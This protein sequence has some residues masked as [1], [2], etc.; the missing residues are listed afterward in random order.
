MTNSPFP[1]QDP[2]SENQQSSSET[3]SHSRLFS[4]L[5]LVSLCT[6]FSRVLGLVRDSCMAIL[7]GNGVVLDAFT[8]AFRLPNLARRL[9][10]EGAL[11]AAFLPHFI[12]VKE[13]SGLKTAFDL[14]RKLLTVL[15]LLLILIVFLLELILGLVYVSF[16]LSPSAQLL[17]TLTVILLPYVIFICLAAQ[18]SAILQSLNRFTW[19]ALL[20]IILN[21]VWIGAIWGVSVEGADPFQ[22]SCVIAVF[23]ADGRSVA[24]AE[25]LAVSAFARFS[26]TSVSPGRDA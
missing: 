2:S 14:S 9:F 1:S 11:T 20:P 7:F 21:V 10:G 26:V 25:S 8:V 16:P 19:P 13:Q 5:R 18:V 17:L 3:S 22:Q 23:P 24:T 6:L 4:H 12:R 15:A